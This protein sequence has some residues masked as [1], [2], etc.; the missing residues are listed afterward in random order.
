[1]SEFKF[2]CPICGQHITADSKDTGSQISCPTCYRKIV[3]PQAPATNDPKFVLS[4]SEAN[5]PRPPST[6]PPFEGFQ[7]APEK[8]G[9][10]TALIILLVLACGA[11]ATLF[12]LR[13]KIFRPKHPAG[14]VADGG[15]ENKSDGQPEY[16]GTN[17]WTLDLS[18]VKFPEDAVGGSIHHRA[19]TLERASITSSNL[20]LRLGR[21]GPMELGVNIYFFNHLPEELSG[22]TAEVKPGDSPAPRVVLHWKD[23]DRVS[24]TFRGGYAMKVEFGPAVNGALPG[25]IFLCLPDDSKSWIAGNF[26][27]EI[28][29]PG[30]PRPR[31]AAPR[32]FQ[33]Q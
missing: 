29:K 15:A 7:K 27:A 33:T 11:G 21:T 17:L 9:F 10:P 2:A 25:K 3:V 22:K 30:P 24:E 20:T 8:P 16:T 4:A 6:T 1:M 14:E 26:R 5:K 12:A 23:A 13:G 19:F 18:D 28:H 32:Q 31:P